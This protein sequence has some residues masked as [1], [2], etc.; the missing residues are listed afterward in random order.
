[1]PRFMLLIHGDN[2]SDNS[3]E[4][5]QRIV[6]EYIA[7]A[8]GLRSEGKMVAGDELD[9][10]GKLVRGH[11]DRVVVSN[12]PV[13]ETKEVIGGYFI[14]DVADEAEAVAVAKACPGLRRGGAV[15]VRAVVEH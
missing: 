3:P 9:E 14:L 13:T 5:M 8:R 2:A 6:E 4:E 10:R 7:W 12:D 1:M 15:Q 11:G